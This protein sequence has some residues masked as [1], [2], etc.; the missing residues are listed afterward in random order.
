MMYPSETTFRDTAVVLLSASPVLL[1]YVGLCSFIVGWRLYETITG[2]LCP[3]ISSSL[4]PPVGLPQAQFPKEV[5][6]IA[7]S[8]PG[9]LRGIA[10]CLVVF[11]KPA[12]TFLE[13]VTLSN[14][15]QINQFEDDTCFLSGSRSEGQDST[16]KS[17]TQHGGQNDCVKSERPKWKGVWG[18]I[19]EGHK[20]HIRTSGPHFSLC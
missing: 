18:Q 5:S 10:G 4:S 7:R 11:P 19:L 20:R 9:C 15:H 2:S 12:F 16:S 17:N 6:P 8:G 1:L 14:T 3:D 13:T